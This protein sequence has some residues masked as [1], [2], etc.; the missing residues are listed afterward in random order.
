MLGA[1]VVAKDTKTHPP[2]GT[3]CWKCGGTKLGPFFNEHKLEISGV[4]FL[5]G[6]HYVAIIVRRTQC[7]NTAC[8]QMQ[9]IRELVPGKAA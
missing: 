2:K 6:K 8:N 5:T 7:K 9:Y 3:E 1:S 4:D